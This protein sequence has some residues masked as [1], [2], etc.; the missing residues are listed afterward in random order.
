MT[1]TAVE[2]PKSGEVIRRALPGARA[3]QI[4]DPAHAGDYLEISIAPGG[5]LLSIKSDTVVL[6][7]RIGMIHE[8]VYSRSMLSKLAVPGNLAC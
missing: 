3:D 7:A 5:T 2:L 8:L 4:E 6:R 1:G